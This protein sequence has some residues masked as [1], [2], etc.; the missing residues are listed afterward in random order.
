MTPET[1][2]KLPEILRRDLD[3]NLCVCNEVTKRKIIDAIE[4]GAT[5]LAMVQRQTYASDG[6]GCCKRQVTRLIECLT[7]PEDSSQD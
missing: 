6:N 7:T 3:E 1:L 2:D 4:S 5:T